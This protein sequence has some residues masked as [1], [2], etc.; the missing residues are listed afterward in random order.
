MTR[1]DDALRWICDAL[2]TDPAELVDDELLAYQDAARKLARAGATEHKVKARVAW[3]REHWYA[4]LTPTELARH[5][6]TLGGHVAADRRT[7]AARVRR[8]VSDDDNGHRATPEERAKVAQMLRDQTAR[9]G[10]LDG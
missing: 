2:G 7:A 10:R 8:T 6:G 1:R 3:W 9:M 4:R 5:W